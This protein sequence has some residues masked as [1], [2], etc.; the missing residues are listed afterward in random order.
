MFEKTVSASFTV[1]GMMCTHCVKHVEDAL[2]SV[3][4]VKKVNVDLDSKTAKAEYLASKTNTSELISAIEK[5]GY[6]AS[7]V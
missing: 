2:K 6:K 5:A 3:P 1:E 4:G 7:A